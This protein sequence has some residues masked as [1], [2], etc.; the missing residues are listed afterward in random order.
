MKYYVQS[1]MD[2]ILNPVI[3]QFLMKKKGGVRPIHTSWIGRI[4]RRANETHVSHLSKG[5]RV[6]WRRVF[7]LLNM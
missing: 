6:L 4:G 5:R 2:T 3:A 1:L 7:L